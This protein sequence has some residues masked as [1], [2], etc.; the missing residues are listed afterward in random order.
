MK[1]TNNVKFVDW[2]TVLTYRLDSYYSSSFVTLSVGFNTRRLGSNQLRR[3][4]RT[5][6]FIL[7][8]I[9]L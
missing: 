8:I 1:V 9:Y 2:L 7:Y 5:D 3:Q 4:V 6:L